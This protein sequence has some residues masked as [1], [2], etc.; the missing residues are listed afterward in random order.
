MLSAYSLESG[1]LQGSKQ[2]PLAGDSFKARARVAAVIQKAGF[3]PLDQG[4]LAA[5]RAIEDIPVSIFPAWRVPLAINLVIFALELLRNFC[6]FFCR[7]N[8]FN[9]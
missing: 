9:F 1:G 7:T 8:L 4:G 3:T 2:V 6:R 5:A